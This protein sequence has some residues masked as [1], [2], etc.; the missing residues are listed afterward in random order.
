MASRP[1][2]SSSYEIMVQ[3]N[4]SWTIDNVQ[5]DEMD[6]LKLAEGL[7]GSK[8][9]DAVKINRVTTATGYEQVIYEENSA[10]DKSGP[11]IT[12]ID[13]APVCK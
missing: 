2:K 11:K 10:R 9:F 3:K 1:R 8:K 4:G 7:L 5:D 13:D 6:A 12:P